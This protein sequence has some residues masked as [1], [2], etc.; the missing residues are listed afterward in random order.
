M[1][2]SLDISYQNKNGVLYPKLQISKNADADKTPLGKYGQMCL[3]FLKEEY[4]ERYSEL[5]MNGEL[6]PLMHEVDEE[7]HRQ[8]KELADK[9]VAQDKGIDRT[10]TMLMYQLRNTWQAAAE[11]IVL[12]EFVY[13]PR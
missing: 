7:A 6:M 11:E 2:K 8:I 9:L 10:D 12:N 4:P 13:Q 1:K 5:R 3:N